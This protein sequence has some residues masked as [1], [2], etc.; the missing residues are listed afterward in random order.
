MIRP[1]RIPRIR[2]DQSNHVPSIMNIQTNR[3][4]NRRNRESNNG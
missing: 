1:F 3:K 4:I 2:L